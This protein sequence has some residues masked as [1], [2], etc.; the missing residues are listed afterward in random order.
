MKAH[1]LKQTEQ[2]HITK[3]SEPD[4]RIEQLWKFFKDNVAEQFEEYMGYGIEDIERIGVKKLFAIYDWHSEQDIMSYKEDVLKIVICPE[5]KNDFGV[6]PS[7]YGLC[8]D[9][10]PKFNAE[11][12][13]ED[14]D[15]SDGNID[16]ATLFLI[17]QEI[18]DV[19]KN[20]V[21]QGWCCTCEEDAK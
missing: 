2:K 10:T 13:S 1:I 9:C 8:A 21:T 12:L 14:V 6:W 19:F 11:K 18:R 4:D 16:M 5:C 15:S 17:D 3:Y 20:P 7:E